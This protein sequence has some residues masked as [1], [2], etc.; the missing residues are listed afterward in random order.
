[1]G[2]FT[3]DPS[4]EKPVYQIDDI[5]R[6]TSPINYSSWLMDNLYWKTLLKGHT[7]TVRIAPIHF[8]KPDIHVALPINTDTFGA[9]DNK[10]KNL[11]RNISSRPLLI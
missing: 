1:M 3:E 9:S 8:V 11:L 5:S 6:P 10:L 7:S 2:L 4:A